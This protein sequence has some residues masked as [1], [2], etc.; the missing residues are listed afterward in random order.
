MEP[1]GMLL[2]NIMLLNT[3]SQKCSKMQFERTEGHRKALFL[4]RVLEKKNLPKNCIDMYKR[5]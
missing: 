1:F 3:L 2:S 4:T 5:P